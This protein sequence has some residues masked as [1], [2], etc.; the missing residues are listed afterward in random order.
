MDKERIR[1][2]IAR[3]LSLPPGERPAAIAA[4][5]GGDT[6]LAAALERGVHEVTVVGPG[7][8]GPG[9]NRGSP[10]GHSPRLESLVPGEEIADGSLRYRLVKRLPGGGLGE[11]WVAEQTAPVRRRVAMKFIRDDRI[12]KAT[13]DRFENERRLLASFD[14][15][16]IARY[17]HD[18]QHGER[19][20]FAMEYVEGDAIDVYC[21]RN[22]LTVEERIRLVQQVARAVQYAHDR[23]VVHRDLKPQNILVST[24]GVP[25][26]L[27]FGI[28]KILKSNFE[29]PRGITSDF[30][31][32][33][34]EY[35]S[36][37][38]L[39]NKSSTTRS[40]V[41]ALGVLL[42]ELL[43]DQLPYHVRTRVRE[44]ILELKKKDPPPP[45]SE[46]LDEVQD[47]IEV[48]PAQGSP[49]NARVDPSSFSASGA[50][51]S[52]GTGSRARR[53]RQPSRRLTD[54]ARSRGTRPERL[55]RQLQGNLDNIVLK[56][57][58]IEPLRRY[59][60]PQALAA[61]LDNHL[62]GLPVIALPESVAARLSRA[63][64]RNRW[65]VAG[66]L[67]ALIASVAVLL[68]VTLTYRNQVL[69]AE[70]VRIEKQR[71]VLRAGF[72]RV[73]RQA[74]ADA[75]R[76][77]RDA[78]DIRR[79]AETL[80][81]MESDYSALAQSGAA[82]SATLR[83]WIETGEIRRR[84]A[85]LADSPANRAGNAG[86]A[87]E[88]DRWLGQAEDAVRQ[89]ME[90]S[91]RIGE[92]VPAS[93]L[94]LSALLA[95]ERGDA[96]MH[97]VRDIVTAEAG[98]RR[99]VAALDQALAGLQPGSSDE[100]HLRRERLTLATTLAD[101]DQKLARHDGLVSA[102]EQVVMGYRRELGRAESALARVDLSIALFRLGE[103]MEIVAGR[104]SESSHKCFEESVEVLRP[105]LDVRAGASVRRAAMDAMLYLADRLL[106]RADT[107]SS[108]E[109][110]AEDRRRSGELFVE[111]ANQAAILTA[112]APEEMRARLDLL[113]LQQ[114]LLPGVGP[115]WALRVIE[116]IRV[117]RIE[118]DRWML[119]ED[120]HV[121]SEAS[122][123]MGAPI[124]R[125]LRIA[126]AN[127]LANEWDVAP[128]THPSV[129]PPDAE[130][131]T[132]ALR[133][134]WELSRAVA[135]GTDKDLALLVEAMCC[136]ALAADPDVAK[137]LWQ[138]SERAARTAESASLARSV[139]DRMKGREGE[140]AG[141]I[142]VAHWF[143]NERLNALEPSPPASGP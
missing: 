129:K 24:D 98:Y 114:M 81:Q 75:S 6:E 4:E 50:P 89:A 9:S 10:G 104:A 60:S 119:R 133:E 113:R 54:I 92:T 58:R 16:N 18:G 12:T 26:L 39:E 23:E 128:K 135:L 38:Q 96:A 106:V 67:V 77:T 78:G 142:V 57:M 25:K 90:L 43:T 5:A 3:I 120:A 72:D 125:A 48:A 83:D 29:G 130:K 91:Q 111:A 27:D 93:A 82:D 110:Q 70:R 30:E 49:A 143:A 112:R 140:L 47:E 87:D 22:S 64:V 136:L 51:R 101:I 53:R 52:R 131:V 56:A 59:D 117:V 124:S 44:A 46:A 28:A 35:A 41:Y 32:R 95:R 80:Q 127:R 31:P 139:R 107:P 62:Q 109:Q 134:S 17:Y 68:S 97:R 123:V 141:A 116:T 132:T 36:P 94:R 69:E 45:M 84:L 99:A 19:P 115:D 122:D 13:L 137:I 74:D 33:T 7:S 37:E 88:A 100:P 34:D 121:P 102:R 108:P 8:S 76:V 105:A 40:D 21:R 118:P 66:S 1:L 65:I 73:T 2:L 11:V 79:L 138:E 15:P 42:Y 126:Y 63:L 61:D 103:A 20:W 71:N 85:V 86:H 55:I 14:H